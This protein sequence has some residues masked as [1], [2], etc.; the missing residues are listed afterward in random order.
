MKGQRA[1]TAIGRAEIAKAENA[2]P[3][4][5]PRDCI[6]RPS[7]CLRKGECRRMDAGK[8]QCSSSDDRARASPMTFAIAARCPETGALGIGIATSSPARDRAACM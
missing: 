5:R 8:A 7:I 6:A 2:S 4:G 1:P 3:K